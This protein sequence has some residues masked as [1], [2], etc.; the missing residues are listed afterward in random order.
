MRAMSSAG[1]YRGVS[2]ADRQRARRGR[3]LEA[4]LDVMA[5]DQW[6]TVTVDQISAA[7][8]LNKRYFYESFP[9]LDTLASA[10]VDDVAAEV[11]D[12]TL[13]AFAEAV[14]LPLEQQA[15]ASVNAVVRALVR[16]PRR[17]RVLLK[18]VAASPSVDSH[19][20]VAMKQLTRILLDHARLIHGVELEHDPLAQVAPAFVVGG[21]AQAVLAFLDGSATIS[22]E[23]LVSE[24]TLLWLIT[25]NGAAE[26]ARARLPKT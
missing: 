13:A 3:L 20:T 17:A 11:R 4:A 2:A 26:V 7:A 8:G 6:R 16:D 24:L 10:V 5:S 18:G 19:R 22:L 12:A 9:D 23:E 14:G 1:K 15:F 21:T 25:G